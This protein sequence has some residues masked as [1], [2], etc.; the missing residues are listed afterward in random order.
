MIVIFLSA[1]TP[2]PN[3]M[4]ARLMVS[5][6]CLLEQRLL[7]LGGLIM[8]MKEITYLNIKYRYTQW[9]EI[10]ARVKLSV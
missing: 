6:F 7:F 4:I 1:N 8:E 2:K 10:V 9:L 5:T 3:V